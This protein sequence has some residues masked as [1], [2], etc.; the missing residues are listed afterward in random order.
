[1]AGVIALLAPIEHFFTII[2]LIFAC[3]ALT[4]A[5]LKAY[6]PSASGAAARSGWRVVMEEFV[7]PMR[8]IRGHRLMAWSFIGVCVTNAFW[9]AALILGLVLVVHE[10][11]PGDVG[12][13]GLVIAAYG[14]GNFA[15]TL[16]IGSLR[17]G[18]QMLCMFPGRAILGLGLIGL[19][20]APSLPV[21]MLIAPLA[22][23]G[24]TMGDLPFL[25]LMQRE[26]DVRQIGRIFGL[27]ITV[28]SVG[29]A[30]GALIA[31]P[32]LDLFSPTIVVAVS[33]VGLVLF[34]MVAVWCTRTEIAQRLRCE[35]SSPIAPS[36]PATTA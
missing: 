29:G 1:M 24:G 12:A 30:A 16:T 14:I 35:S 10:R 33:G 11:L 8:A 3:S 6:L 5:A 28:E 9:N 7:E 20:F 27:R 26:F 36:G 2:A 18:P 23:I 15:A 32:C 17:F 34:S 21:F 19:A 13:Y 4:V 22:A 31:A 25:G